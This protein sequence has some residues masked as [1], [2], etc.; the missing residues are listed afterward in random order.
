MSSLA[1]RSD[2]GGAPRR[3]VGAILLLAFVLI[4]LP[5]AA[6]CFVRVFYE[7]NPDFQLARQIV[8]GDAKVHSALGEIESVRFRGITSHDVGSGNREVVIRLVADGQAESG[9]I[10][11]T[12]LRDSKGEAMRSYVSDMRVDIW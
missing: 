10:Y 5:I 6:A 4:I 7:K 2:T 8:L 1:Y 11:V 12:I 9:T 3:S